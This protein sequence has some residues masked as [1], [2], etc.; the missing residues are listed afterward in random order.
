MTRTHKDL[1]VW[2]K[3][4]DFVTKIYKVTETFPK[5]EMYGLSS[6]IRRASVSI[7]SNI[8]EGSARKGKVEFKQFLYISL[9]SAAEVDTQLLIS[10][11]L[12][13]LELSKYED[14]GSQ[15]ETISKMLQGLIKSIDK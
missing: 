1:D 5:S 4:I 12:G 3:S 11:N 7:P 10:L 9:S 8:A 2:K 6:Q 14:L 15:L 13:Y